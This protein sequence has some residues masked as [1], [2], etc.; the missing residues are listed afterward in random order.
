MRRSLEEEVLLKRSR[1]DAKGEGGCVAVGSLRKGAA[2]A[3]AIVG[4][5]MKENGKL[6]KRSWGRELVVA[7]DPREQGSGEEEVEEEGSFPSEDRARTKVF[8]TPT[9]LE[10][11]RGSREAK[12]L[13]ISV[14]LLVLGRDLRSKKEEGVLDDALLPLPLLLD[15]GSTRLP[16]P[17]PSGTE[18]P[19]LSIL[20]SPAVSSSPDRSRFRSPSATSE[21][22]TRP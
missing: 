14:V 1:E 13:P 6:E 11:L 8:S 17:S 3:G 18:I 10:D 20:S 19:R 5:K 15:L 2:V 16:S 22:A 4:T 12:E 9:Q 21:D 7:D